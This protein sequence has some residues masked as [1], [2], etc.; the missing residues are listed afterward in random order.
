MQIN[1]SV[2][3]LAL[4]FVVAKRLPK[5]VA[6]TQPIL[7]CDKLNALFHGQGKVVFPNSPTYNTQNTYWST[8]SYE[9]PTCI[10]TPAS[11]Q[12]VSKA[13]ALFKQKSCIFAI[14]SGGHMPNLGW[15]STSNGVLVSLSGL[16][17]LHYNAHRNLVQIGTGNRWNNVYT[18]L[19]PYNVTALG[20]RDSSVGVGGS[21]LGGAIS[22]LSNKHGWATDN[23]VD[24]EIVLA[25]GRIVHANQGQNADLLRALRGGSSNFGIVTSITAKTYSL[26]TITSGVMLYPSSSTNLYLQALYNY[27]VNGQ[28]SN[29][30]FHIIS[31]FSKSPGQGVGVIGVPFWAGEPVSL[32]NA[33]PVMRPFTDGSVPWNAQFMSNLTGM[34]GITTALIAPLGNA[35]RSQWHVCSIIANLQLFKDIVNIWKTTIAPYENTIPGISNSIAFQPIGHE[36]ID[37]AQTN[38][39]NS[40]GITAPLVIV[41]SNPYWINAADDETMYALLAK[42]FAKIKVAAIRAN[43]YVPFEYLNY[44]GINQDPIASY[45]RQSVQRLANSKRKYDPDNVFGKLVQGGFK[46][47]GF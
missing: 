36:F 40:F 8:S 4:A 33:P 28:D 39:G 32:S 7:C 47:P 44:G 2:I 14:R 13:V 3:L 25:D 9:T 12:D 11:A 34:A 37:A 20:A 43:K 42:L 24:F 17:S 45:G 16:T 46:V 26:S 6:H 38:G 22:F 10:F 18:Y 23:V 35:T 27:A 1:T 21:I 31:I 19:D 41:S 5:A 15:S 29:P 30:N